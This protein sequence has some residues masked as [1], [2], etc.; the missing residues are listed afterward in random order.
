MKPRKMNPQNFSLLLLPPLMNPQKMNLQ[1]WRWR[2]NQINW[3]RERRNNQNLRILR[4]QY[5][6]SLQISCCFFHHWRTHERGTPNHE[7]E[8]QIE[9]IG[10][11]RE[12][13]IA[14]NLYFFKLFSLRSSCLTGYKF[15]N[16]PTC[17]YFALYNFFFLKP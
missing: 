8:D 13:S 14:Q 17:I 4:N 10:N 7:E 11:E 1:L 3:D 16:T 15:S 6:L 5:N 2:P 12:E 9:T